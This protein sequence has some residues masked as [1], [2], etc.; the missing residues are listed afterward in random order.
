MER[1]P[2]I[3][4][5]GPGEKCPDSLRSSAEK[6][7]MAIGDAGYNLISGGRKIGVMDAVS[8]GAKEG[9]SMVIGILPGM[10]NS[11]A[12]EWLDVSIATGAGSARNNFIVLS[13]DVVIAFGKG[14]G[15]FS[16][17]ALAIKAGKP[18]ILFQP[19]A[20]LFK[21]AKSMGKKIFEADS[22]EKTMKITK[23][24]FMPHIV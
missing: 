6:I 3:A 15:T 22:V 24:Y 11:D 16:E 20:N 21:L 7:G 4:V 14:A 8:K 10:D 19:E 9:G 12:S 18:L 23:K 13:A 1:K 5:I 17:I 2:L